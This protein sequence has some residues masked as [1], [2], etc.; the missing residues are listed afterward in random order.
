[1]EN[2]R[3]WMAYDWFMLIGA[4]ILLALLIVLMVGSNQPVPPTGITLPA[5]PAASFTW[6]YDAAN[7][8]LLDPQGVQMYTLSADWT[9]W[10]PVIP[11]ETQA[12]LPSGYQLVQDPAAGWVIRYSDGTLLY[13]WDV[14]AFRWNAAQTAQAIGQQPVPGSTPLPAAAVAAAPTVAPTAVPTMAFAAAPGAAPTM[15]PSPATLETPAATEAPPA[16]AAA[17]PTSA[18]DCQPPVPARLV[19]GKTARVL[20]ALNMRSEP[21]IDDNILTRNSTGTVL[22]VLQ[23]PVC[24]PHE[25][26]AYLWWQVES[27]DG[28]TGWSAENYSNGQGYFLEPIP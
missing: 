21:V 8:A 25:N 15:S 22:T 7:Q 20:S 12:A 1:M 16:E 9:T 10:Q 5:Y 13:T 4:L 3:R 27:S 18:A 17:A 23:G 26:S 14:Q 11:A 24:V 6:T 2:R 19:V 28:T